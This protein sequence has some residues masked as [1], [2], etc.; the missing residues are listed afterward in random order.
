MLLKDMYCTL[1]LK[2]VLACLSPPC[3]ILITA[4]QG[5]H[6]MT[7]NLEW[8]F[9]QRSITER[10]AFVRILEKTWLFTFSKLRS[11]SGQILFGNECNGA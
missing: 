5:L 9:K 2:V 3:L 11:S 8:Q 10:K 1:S 4:S 7:S 6:R